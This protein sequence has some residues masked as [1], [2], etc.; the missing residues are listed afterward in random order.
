MGKSIEIELEVPEEAAAVQEAAESWPAQAR[1]LVI[2]ADADVERAG[3]MLRGIKALRAE[4]EDVFGPI[5][6]SAHEAWKRALAGRK[7]VEN[8]LEDA[9]R[10]IKG[11]L[12]EY[13]AEQRARQRAEQARLEAEARKRDEERRRE[14]A[15]ALEAAGDDEA[16]AA[17][18]DE[19]A[20]AVVVAPPVEPR[21]EGISYRETWSARIDDPDAFI[22]WAA[23][24]GTA[25][26]GYW[27]PNTAALNAAA[28]AQKSALSI[29]GVTAVSSTGV[30]ARSS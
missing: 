13:H 23:E 8:P 18:L 20:A 30:A 7:R 16:A 14:E 9:E 19:P 24:Q 4:I 21:V 26:R 2:I 5:V 22:R 10:T 12:A 15:A 28:R 11:R 25:G 1:G 29:P 3:A 6:R 27:K 17:V